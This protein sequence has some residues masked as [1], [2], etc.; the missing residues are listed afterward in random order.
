MKAD[1]LFKDT[2]EETDEITKNT[3]NQF[4]G[5]EELFKELSTDTAEEI[6]YEGVI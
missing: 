4:I 3:D 1:E 6:F 5:V 2:A